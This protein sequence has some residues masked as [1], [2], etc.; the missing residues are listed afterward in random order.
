MNNMMSMYLTF[1][2]VVQLLL[3]V[4]GLIGIPICM[5]PEHTQSKEAEPHQHLALAGI[6]TIVIFTAILTLILICILMTNDAECLSCPYL[7]YFLSMKFIFK[8]F[9][10]V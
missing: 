4:T 2:D 1:S 10:H 3:K 7:P 9:A 6:I 5:V 8:P